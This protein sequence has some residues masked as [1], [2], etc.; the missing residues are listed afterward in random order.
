MLELD[1]AHTA[2]LLIIKLAQVP[3]NLL[4]LVCHLG[5]DVLLLEGSRVFGSLRVLE[6]G[7]AVLGDT[8]RC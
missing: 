7:V 3:V 6:A 8:G 2:S 1:S 4:P 5:L